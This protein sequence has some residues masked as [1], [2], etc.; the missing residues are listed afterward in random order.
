MTD[1]RRRS[2]LYSNYRGG[3]FAIAGAEVTPAAGGLEGNADACTVLVRFAR[4][5]IFLR[6]AT[7]LLRML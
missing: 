5:C 1:E 4:I 3:L 2:R 7:S 6:R